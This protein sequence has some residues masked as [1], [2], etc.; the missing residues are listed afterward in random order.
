MNK[1]TRQPR[2]FRDFHI[3]ELKDTENARI[4]LEVA[5][6]EYKK[7][8]DCKAFLKAI[9]DVAEAQG[10]LRDRRVEDIIDLETLESLF[11]NLGF[12]LSIELEALK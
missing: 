9:E 1:Q 11:R 8:H 10:G 7:D 6:A 3:D 2:D 4:Y 12:R 5:R